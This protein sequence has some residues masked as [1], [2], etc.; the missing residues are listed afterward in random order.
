MFGYTV[1]E[2]VFKF[3]YVA[4]VF[5]ARERSVFR[6]GGCAG[7]CQD[8]VDSLGLDLDVKVGVGGEFE[9]VV[10]HVGRYGGV[11]EEE[12]EEEEKRHD[13]DNGSSDTEGV[14][15]GNGGQYMFGSV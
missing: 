3:A 8:V 9:G 11:E 13:G 12:D 2:V 15:R 6:G 10:G 14:L 1:E 5:D 4:D 7:G